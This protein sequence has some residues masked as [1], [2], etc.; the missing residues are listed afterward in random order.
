MP[1]MPALLAFGA[2]PDDCELAAAGLAALY[3]S[4]GGRVCFVALTNGDC[5]H[6]SMGGAEL[7]RRRRGEARAAAAAVGASSIVLDNHDGALM[8]TLENRLE[9]IR[10][11]REFRPDLVLCPRPNDYHPDHRYTS[12]LVQDASYMVT[13]PNVAAFTPRLEADPV[14]M[15]VSD[16]FRR[17]YPFAPDVLVDTTEVVERK[18]DALHCHASQ[19]YEWLAWHDGVAETVPAD[20]AGR[21]AWLR[22]H[23]D[24]RLR[25][26]AV[27][28]RDALIERYGP[29]RGA[30]IE[31]AEAFEACEYGS[32]LTD[33][34]KA[35]LFPF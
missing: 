23:Y 11:I 21:R 30:G 29:D 32:P 6:Q 25:G 12:I 28:F 22:A 13:V 9:L 3:S 17:P 35:R 31:Y 7:A 10:I 1:E 5:G 20:E 18:L 4:R 8:P 16:R 14:V 15:Y 27:R 26:D 33:D 24:A 34:A 19:V 2:H